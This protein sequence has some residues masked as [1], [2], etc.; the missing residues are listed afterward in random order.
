MK[1]KKYIYLILSLF[2]AALNFNLI[3]KPLELV[4]GGTQGVAIIINHLINVRPSLII[5]IINTIM[6][7]LSFIFLSHETT[8]G[9]IIATF[10]YPL[11][12]RLTSNIPF[13]NFN[14]GFNIIL[15]I[16]AGIICGIT[17]GII[18]KQGFSNGGISIIPLLIN[19]YFH[20]KVYLSTFIMNGI[21]VILGCFYFGILKTI[22]SVIV[23]VLQ[24]LLIKIILRKQKN[25]INYVYQIK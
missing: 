3:L 19:K 14:N 17:G 16:I 5:L 13:F 15:V 22:Y 1:F 7:L 21:I 24:S 9:T 4:V 12:V 10:I 6:L 23:I 2:L 11:L 8:Y 20:I 25:K 18:Y